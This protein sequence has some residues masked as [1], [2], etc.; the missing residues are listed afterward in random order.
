MP[1][2]ARAGLVYQE[3]VRGIPGEEGGK[4]SMTAKQLAQR[5]GFSVTD[6]D[7]AL[8]EGCVECR[9]FGGR[10]VPEAC[11]SPCTGKDG[12]RLELVMKAGRKP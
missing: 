4:E 7:F 9:V 2:G 1:E 11:A 10:N 5:L 8:K 12:F 3:G 6:L